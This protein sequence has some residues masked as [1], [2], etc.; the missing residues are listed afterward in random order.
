[1]V[2]IFCFVSPSSD[3]DGLST[4]FIKY[5][6]NIIHVNMYIYIYIFSSYSHSIL[7]YYYIIMNTHNNYIVN[8][9]SI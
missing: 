5:Y 2:T 7:L 8:G 9:G 4:S 1:M 3:N 6:N